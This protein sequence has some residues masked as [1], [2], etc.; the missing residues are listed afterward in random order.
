MQTIHCYFCQRKLWI[1]AANNLHNIQIL[2]EKKEKDL[3]QRQ[4]KHKKSSYIF[5]KNPEK[6]Q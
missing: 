6:G 3:T 4:C 5:S 2:I 1:P